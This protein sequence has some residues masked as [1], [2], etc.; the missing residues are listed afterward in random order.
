MNFSVQLDDF[1]LLEEAASSKC[2]NVRFGSEFCEIKMPSLEIL[3]SAIDIVHEKR[4][5]I[6]YVTPRLSNLGIEK[7]RK[8]LALLNEKGTM[9]VVV[10]DLGALNLIGNFDNLHPVLGRQLT[11]VPA[12]SPWTTMIEESGMLGNKRFN[13]VFN[14]TSLNYGLTA[15][16]FQ[17][18]GI[19]D[20]DLDWITIPNFDFLK[21][22]GF[23]LNVH[24]Q[25]VPITLAR[26]CHTARFVGEKSP[27]ECSQPCMENAYLLKLPRKEVET[28]YFLNEFLPLPEL[29]LHGNV[30]FKGAQP[31]REDIKKLKKSGVEEFIIPINPITLLD[32]TQ[33]IN[34]FIQSFK[35]T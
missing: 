31:L 16:F 6:S 3:E 8:Q 21:N 19:K 23:S 17:S 24:L 7:L 2:D 25:L 20:V 30:V 22:S 12:R 35:N 14:S 28:G 4:K 11:R 29:F 13:R 15:K 33:K 1:R 9:K 18:Y 26:R 34:E 5:K 10:N 32:K 27:E